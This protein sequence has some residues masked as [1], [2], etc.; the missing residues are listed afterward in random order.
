[1]AKLWKKD[2]DLDAEVEAFTVGDDYVLDRALAEA[3]ALASI[4]HARTIARAGLLTKKELAA[5]EKGLRAIV[6]D[7]RAGKFTIAREDED[8]HTAIENRLTAET[9]EAGKKIHACRSR[10]DQVIAATRVWARG[11]ALGLAGEVLSLAG[12]LCDFAKANADVPVVG[13]THMQPAM[14]SSLGLWAAAYAESLLDGLSLLRAGA[15]L[16]D[17][18][19]LGSAA[20]YGVPVEL[21][22]EFTARELGFSRAQNN[23]LYANTSR[24]KFEAALLAAAS[25]VML[26][27][28]RLAQDAILYSLPEFGYIRLPRE[29]CSGSSI[30]PQKKNPCA[31][32]LV[33]AKAAGV[34]AAEGEVLQL[35]RAL[36]SGYNRDHQETKRPFLRALAATR[37]SVRVVDLTVRRLE[38]DREACLAAFTPEVFATDAALER[39]AAGTP[40][41]DA[42]REVGLNLDK[43]AARDPVEAIR[44]KTH[45]GGTGRLNLCRAGELAAEHGAWIDAARARIG[46]AERKLLGE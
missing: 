5:L 9:G 41:R 7:A 42:Y 27:L 24:G 28:S 32:E 40:W 33:R 3:D 13:R 38:V 6:K 26:D 44:K 31:L 37:A 2:Y 34:I 16:L 15:E 46:K 12:A 45:L 19:P 43:L 20:S 23:V 1:M 11:E 10:N 36:P 21:D 30:M 35:L 4:A 29:L 8:V 18:C 17:Q 25:H 39:A 22:R 14:P